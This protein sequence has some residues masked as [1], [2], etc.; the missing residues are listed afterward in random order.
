MVW[1]LTYSDMQQG[2]F[3]K[4]TG[5]MCIYLRHR[6]GTLEFQRIDMQHRDP[7]PDPGPQERLMGRGRSG[8]FHVSAQSLF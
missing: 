6:D 5:D 8:T 7:P 3:L 4:S 1:G 2:F